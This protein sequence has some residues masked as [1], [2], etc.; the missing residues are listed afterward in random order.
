MDSVPREIREIAEDYIK[1]ISTQI[2]IKKAILFGS[3]VKGTF[4]SG[5]DID[6]AIFSDYFK[7]MKRIESFRFLFLQAMDY[8]VDLQPQSFTNED[9]EYPAGIVKEIVS[10][11]IEIPFS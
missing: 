5:S 4:N 3:F 8:D 10:T 7:D 9:L 1:K 11:G 2:P 6:I